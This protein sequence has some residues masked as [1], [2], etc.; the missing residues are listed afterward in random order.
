MAEEL[1]QCWKCKSDMTLTERSDNDGD[2]LHCGAEIDLDDYL[3]K[4]LA[5]NAALRAAPGQVA[6]GVVVSREL[7]EGVLAYCDQLL[8]ELNGMYQYS[9]STGDDKQHQDADYAELRQLL[10]KSE[11]VKK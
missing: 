7:L 1:I 6:E 8:C 3:A 10:A 9:G 2:C 5:E 4:A 11:G